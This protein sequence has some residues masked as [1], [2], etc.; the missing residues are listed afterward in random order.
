M[1][2]WNQ[3]SQFQNRAAQHSHCASLCLKKASPVD[4]FLGATTP[5]KQKAFFSRANTTDNARCE[6]SQSRFPPSSSFTTVLGTYI[7]ASDIAAAASSTR[8]LFDR[9]FHQNRGGPFRS[10]LLLDER[11]HRRGVGLHVVL[12][13]YVRTVHCVKCVRA[14]AAGD[15]RA[16][17]WAA[18]T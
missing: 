16:Q 12:G 17:Q 9:R 14:C 18:T 6:A 5:K 10:R 3:T 4:P 8:F 13:S 2:A 15:L 7:C 11:R 1:Q